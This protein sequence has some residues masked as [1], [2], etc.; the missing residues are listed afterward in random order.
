MP[1]ILLRGLLGGLLPDAVRLLGGLALG[2]LVCLVAALYA[3]PALLLAPSRPGQPGGTGDPPPPPAHLAAIFAEVE[4]RTGVPAS[5]LTALASVESG[6][7]PAARGP[8]IA[9]FAGTE[10]AHALGLMQFLPST[11]R[12]LAPRV[13][14]LTGVRLGESGVWSPRHAVYGA[15]L[16]L[17]EHGAPAD[18]RRALFAYNRDDAYV[19]RVLALAAAYARAAPAGDVAARALAHARTQ[20]G[21]PYLWGG[22]GPGGF[23]CSGLTQWAYAAAGARLPRTAAA[24]FH[25]TRRLSRA[26][27]QPGDLVFFDH[28]DPGQPGVTITHV[29]LY[30]GDGLMLDAPA[31]GAVVRVEPLWRSFAGGGRVATRRAGD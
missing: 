24:Q 4:G 21:K 11:Y 10:D 3:I 19:E 13:D 27:L 18:L 23:D 1:A 17:K 20:L 8:L 15:A 22:T 5:L 9:R 25:A 28:A 30:A 26:E 2:L 29:G 12:A 7:D 14:A 31:P 6:F 16:Y